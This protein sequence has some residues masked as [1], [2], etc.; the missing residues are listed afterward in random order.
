MKKWCVIEIITIIVRGIVGI[1]WIPLAVFGLTTL[2][3]ID[4]S[5]IIPTCV[6]GY[7]IEL[8]AETKYLEARKAGVP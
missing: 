8:F 4:M 6:I 5:A 2:A 1:A 7:A 3:L